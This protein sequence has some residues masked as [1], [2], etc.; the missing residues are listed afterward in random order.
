[1]VA[2]VCFDS[3][4]AIAMTGVITTI[5]GSF[6]NAYPNKHLI[7][8]SY[9]EQMKD[10]VPSLIASIAMLLGVLAVELLVLPDIVTLVVQ[11][12]TGAGLYTIISAVFRMAPFRVILMLV[13]QKT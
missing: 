13:R 9:L 2:V 11:I 12:V 8:Y 6:I 1:M 10:I 4:I 7:G 3:P 5:T